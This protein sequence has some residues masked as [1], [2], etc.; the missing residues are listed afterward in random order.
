MDRDKIDPS[1]KLDKMDQG[2]NGSRQKG[3][4]GSRHFV[5]STSRRLGQIWTGFYRTGLKSTFS[6]I[7]IFLFQFL[8]LAICFFEIFG[9]GH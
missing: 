5:E 4:N 6:P 3:Q 9:T 2:Q 8:C 1:P 7:F